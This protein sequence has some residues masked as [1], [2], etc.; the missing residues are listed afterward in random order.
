MDF[1][2]HILGSGSATPVKNRHQSAQI[3]SIKQHHFLI[4]CGEGTQFRL[5]DQGISSHKI[6]AIFISHLHGDHYLGI[7]GLIST[8]GMLGRKRPLKIISPPGLAE[9]ITT[10]FRISHTVLD[11]D[12]QVN[13]I[14]VSQKHLVFEN[15]E[16]RVYAFPL[17]HGVPTQGYFFEEKPS[18]RKLR[19][20]KLPSDILIQEMVLLKAGQ[21][22]KEENGSI[23]YAVEDFTYPRMK[24]RSYAYC[25]DTEYSE[26]V[27]GFIKDTNVLYHETTYLEAHKEKAVKNRH[28][29]AKEAALIASQ[30]GVGKLLI[31]HISSRY[32]DFED[33]LSEAKKHFLNTEAAFEGAVFNV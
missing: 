19:K 3:V 33:H 15:E 27:V 31:G 25:S 22:V 29:T 4:D 9:I 10:H 17:K 23:K 8:M 24:C 14:L 21:D 6:E 7:V 11:Y 1:S 26:E 32:H 2:I 13:E 18:E 5:V 30:A 16:T 20:E 12:L 28:C